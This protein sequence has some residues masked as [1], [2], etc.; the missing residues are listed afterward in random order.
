MTVRASDDAGNEGT[1]TTQITVTDTQKPV[2]TLDSE[3]TV[4]QYNE[5]DE[6]NIV[7]STS[8]SY[9]GSIEV[10]IGIPE[11]A[12]ADGKL[13]AGEWTITLTATDAAGNEADPVT[14][15][16]NVA[17][18]ASGGCGSTINGT[19]GTFGMVAAVVICTVVLVIV[20]KRKKQV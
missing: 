20:F 19:T 13:V 5:G 17:E 16:I 6:L 3:K 4:T 12:V 15:Q 10:E 2:I 14:V 7:A 8:D 9:D 11:G 18:N 1:A